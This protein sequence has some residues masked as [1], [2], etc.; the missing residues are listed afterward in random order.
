MKAECQDYYVVRT[1]NLPIEY[2][3][4]YECQEQDIYEFI[5]QD[6]ELDRF[7]RKALLIASPTLYNSYV[8]KPMDEKKYK[9]R[10]NPC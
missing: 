8:N 6:A 10:Q 4:K 7:F 3:N 5:S 1:P 9:N 2:L